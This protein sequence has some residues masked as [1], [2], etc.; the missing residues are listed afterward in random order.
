MSARVHLLRSGLILAAGAA[1][2]VSGSPAMAAL[3]GEFALGQSCSAVETPDDPAAQVAGMRA[4]AWS[5]RCEGWEDTEFG[6]IY[7]FRRHGEQAVAVGGKWTEE[8]AGRAKCGAS[9]GANV[10]MLA[11]ATVAKCTTLDAQTPYVVYQQADDGRVVVAEGLQSL[12]DVVQTGLRI[13]AGVEAAPNSGATVASGSTPEIESL[14]REER[15]VHNEPGWL[16]EQAFLDNLGWDFSN[17]ESKCRNIQSQSASDQARDLLCLALNVSNEGRSDEAEVYFARA[18][19]LIATLHEP[20][21]AALAAN[22]RAMHLRNQHAFDNAVAAAQQAKN[23]LAA[24]GKTEG[25]VAASGVTVNKAGDIDIDDATA[26]A[27]N[28]GGRRNGFG[29][30][31]LSP[32]E[33]ARVLEAQADF[34]IATAEEGRGR[35]PDARRALGDAT[36]LFSRNPRLGNAVPWL[37]ARV[38]AE[39]GRLDMKEGSPASA[40]GDYDQAIEAFARQ[41]RINPSAAEA[42]L[43]LGRARAESTVGDATAARDDYDTGFKLFRTTRKTLGDSANEA[44]PYLDMLIQRSA[45]EPSGAQESQ[46]AFFDAVQTVAN[47]ETAQTVAQAAA[48]ISQGNSTAAWIARALDDERRKIAIDNS[49]IKRKQASANYPADEQRVDQEA[50]DK[51][52]AE[53][54]KLEQKLASVDPH[55]EILAGSTSVGLDRL[56]KSL[57]PGEIYVKTLVLA[58]GGYAIAVTSNSAQIYKIPLSRKDAEEKVRKL[59]KAFDSSNVPLFD[60]TAS[61]ELF[62]AIFG[63]VQAQ[64]AGAR[65][66]IYEPD[67]PLVALPAAV[68]IVD[69]KSV[70]DYTSRVKRRIAGDQSVT[71]FYDGANWLARNTQISLSVSP[72]AFLES[73]NAPPSPATKNLA[74]FGDPRNQG[75]ADTRLYS[76]V[77]TANDPSMQEKCERER[78]MLARLIEPLA[79][80]SETIQKIAD[81]IGGGDVTTGA[82]FTDDAVL[83]RTDLNSYRVLYFGT[84]GLLPSPHG[85]LKEPALVTS[86]GAGKDSDGLLDSVDILKLH[87][88]A[89]L[90]V[91][92]ACNTGGVGSAEETRTGLKGSGQAL[93]GLARD[94]IYVGSRNLIVSQ[95]SVDVA[96]S[97][98]MMRTLFE[99]GA[100]SQGD[101]LAK[102]ERSLM[103]SKEGRLQHPYYWAAFSLLGD[104]AKPMPIRQPGA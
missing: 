2:L 23:I 95:W 38:D 54:G 49:T 6:H 25:Q 66:L 77:V 83:A 96:S 91:L 64:V 16:R 57:H 63:P 76:S 43:Y 50:M 17:S 104:G 88:D 37:L 19:K 36:Q 58:D 8:L 45:A 34:I 98:Q 85:C 93:E 35:P 68:F 89:D 71:A 74:A 42:R 65:Q 46:S 3:K 14:A 75:I 67:G 79:G 84:H 82:A 21:L 22:C 86:L 15:A 100:A 61:H 30:T 24:I 69:Q 4:R 40:R 94:F 39:A 56:Q 29:A 102:A 31:E 51:D 47:A 80:S 41:E 48:R 99:P 101:A 44:A 73:R 12:D 27:L 81:E 5:I 52:Q 90:V 78:Q 33:Q 28:S 26:A 32:Y 103:D 20:L 18:D 60:E 97:E 92:P 9:S 72:G 7:L 11:G 10:S 13:A 87:L 53:A 1:A 62:A 55:Y 59:R 70:D